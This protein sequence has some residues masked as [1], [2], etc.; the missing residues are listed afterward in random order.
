MSHINKRSSFRLNLQIP[1]S[2][3]FKIIGIK[4]K[5]ADTKHSKIMIKD[6]SAGGIRI[7]TPLNLPMDMNLLLEFTFLLFHQEMK[8]LGVIKRKMTLDTTLYEYGIE[9]SIADPLVEQQLIRHLIQLSTRL[10]DTKMLAN[11]SFCS[12]EDIADILSTTYEIT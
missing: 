9:F 2:A 3:L 1:L 10:K 6:I 4:N 7:H 11:C 12:D 8:V 5:A